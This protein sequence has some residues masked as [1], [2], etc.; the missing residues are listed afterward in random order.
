MK[1]PGYEKVSMILSAGEYD[2]CYKPKVDFR[3]PYGRHSNLLRIRKDV[4]AI[5][6][7]KKY[8]PALA[9][10]AMS[11]N[12]EICANSLEDISQIT[13]LPYDTDALEKAIKEI[14]EI[15]VY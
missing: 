9:G 5:D 11:G 1:L 8:T 13:F 6:I 7:L 2:F 14:S 12:P 15:I 10:I 4:R 3:K